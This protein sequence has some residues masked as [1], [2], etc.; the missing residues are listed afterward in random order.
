MKRAD[1][2]KP[3][4]AVFVR[5]NHWAYLGRVKLFTQ[6]NALVLEEA[7]WVK[8]TG[9]FSDFLKDGPTDE[10]E[11][12][13]FPSPVTFCLGDAWEITAWP[14]KLPREAM[15]GRSEWAPDGGAKKVDPSHACHQHF[16]SK[17]DCCWA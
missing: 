3:G 10:A 2:F 14:H 9:L 7:S 15:W 12:E 4:D 6:D 11:I 5:T 13:S 17:H 16:D 1:L 8:N